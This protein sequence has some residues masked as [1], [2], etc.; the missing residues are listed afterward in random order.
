MVRLSHYVRDF[1]WVVSW[2]VVMELASYVT[3]RCTRRAEVLTTHTRRM[4]V[5]LLGDM[6]GHELSATL[7]HGDASALHALIVTA[8]SR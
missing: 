1:G 7:N 3:L 4:A 8:H 6:R 2:R 5:R